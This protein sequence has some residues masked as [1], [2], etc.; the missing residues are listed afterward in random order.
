MTSDEWMTIAEAAKHM[1]LSIPAIRKYIRL[2]KITSYHQGRLVRLKKSD[3]NA[4]LESGR[5]N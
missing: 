2:G 4:F 1:K 5:R 3:L